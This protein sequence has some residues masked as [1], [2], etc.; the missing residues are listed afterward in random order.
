[1]VFTM[2]ERLE[3]YKCNVCGNLI[4]VLLPGVGELVCCGEPMEFLEPHI[5]DSEYG[6]KH[7]PVF[8]TTDE[9]GE[10][11]RVGATLHPMTD[12]HYIQFIETISDGKNHVELQYYTPQDLPIMLLK[13]KLGVEK[14]RAF[15]NIHGLWEGN[16]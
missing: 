16:K 8:V 13:D 3:L 11:V 2:S 14:A 1:M 9:K 5:N 12:E 6:E 7:V 10:E 15:C 4:E